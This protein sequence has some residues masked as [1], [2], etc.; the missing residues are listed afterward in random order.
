MSSSQETDTTYSPAPGACMGLEQP[1]NMKKSQEHEHN[2]TVSYLHP[3]FQ[4]FIEMSQCL[5]LHNHG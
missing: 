1:K 3:S 5:S 2:E 4:V